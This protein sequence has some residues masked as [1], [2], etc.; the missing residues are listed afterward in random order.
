MD[1]EKAKVKK[2]LQQGFPEQMRESNGH[3][4]GNE[5]ERFEMAFTTGCY[6]T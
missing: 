5:R 3:G 2:N 1:H 6:K 4:Y